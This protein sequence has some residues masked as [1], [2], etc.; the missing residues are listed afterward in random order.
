MA[1]IDR[2]HDLIHRLGHRQRHLVDFPK[3]VLVRQ[4]DRAG[5]ITQHGNLGQGCPE[6]VVNIAGNAGT[7][8]F[9]GLLHLESLDLALVP[10]PPT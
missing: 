3:I 6:I 2:P 9:R 1:R 10:P 5:R 7:L 8:A 4:P